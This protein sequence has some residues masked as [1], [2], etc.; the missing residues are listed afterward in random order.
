[1]GLDSGTGSG[2]A[3]VLGIILVI[4]SFPLLYWNEGRA[5]QSEVALGEEGSGV[6]SVTDPSQ[7]NPA[8]E[9]KLVHVTGRAGF[10]SPVPFR[11]DWP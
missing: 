4:G 11:P 6:H 1:M 10:R 8:D 7:V 5:I 3:T 2:G 9:G